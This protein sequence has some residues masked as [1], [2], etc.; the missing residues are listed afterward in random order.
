MIIATEETVAYKGIMRRIRKLLSV[1]L[2]SMSLFLL[3]I[4][5]ATADWTIIK[6]DNLDEWSDPGRWWKTENGMFVAESAG[7][8]SLPK[9]HYLEWNGS[10]PKDLELSLEYRIIATAPQDAGVCIR[11]ERPH[12]KDLGALPGLQA[13]LDTGYLYDNKWL[14]KQ[15]KLFGHIHDGKRVHMF[16]RALIST[17]HPDGTIT[18]K[19]LPGGFDP[20]NVFKKPPEWNNCRIVA[21][22]EHVQLFLNDVLANEIY[23]H[24]P[25]ARSNGDGIALQYRPN[26]GYR[27]E[28]RNLKFRAA[29]KATPPASP[30][31]SPGAEVSAIDLALAGDYSGAARSM[32]K[33]FAADPAA[34]DTVSGLGLAALYSAAGEKEKHRQ[35]CEQFFAKYSDWKT[36]SDASR[37]AKAYSLFPGADDPVLSKKAE[38]AARHAVENGRGGI[39]VWYELTLAMVQYRKGDFAGAEES[40]KNPL[41]SNRA[42]Q[43]IPARAFAAMIAYKQGQIQNARRLLGAAEGHFRNADRSKFNWND[44]VAAQIAIDEA[45]ALIR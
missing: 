4:G 8:Q 40:L 20:R 21:V 28:I 2:S 32:E 12:A 11:V 38:A 37:P 16:K 44:V 17:A 22:G 1:S 36:P 41:Q 6:A 27:F 18:T 24:D 42:P 14:I 7:G 30:Q 5:S 34:F 19:P 31:P 25:K 39:R 13:E 26:G 10:T 23:D 15:G 43:K 45:K 29:T 3:S 33:E 35:F 9:F